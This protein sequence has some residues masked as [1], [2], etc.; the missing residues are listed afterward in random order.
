MIAGFRSASLAALLAGEAAAR[1]V[2]RPSPFV[3]HGTRDDAPL[4]QGLWAFEPHL[5]C[6]EFGAKFE[7]I[8]VIDDDGVR[9]LDDTPAW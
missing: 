1:V 5:G 4:Q 7:E 9:W 8:L 6:A 3:R 2:G